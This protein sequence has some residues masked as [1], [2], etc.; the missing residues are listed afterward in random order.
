M[1]YNEP[2]TRQE[3][4]GK[5]TKEIFNKKTIRIKEELLNKIKI[6]K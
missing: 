1:E 3:K 2:K 6:R 5:K 4:K